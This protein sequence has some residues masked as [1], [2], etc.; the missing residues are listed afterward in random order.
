M[1]DGSRLVG[2]RWPSVGGERQ[3]VGGGGGRHWRCC[4]RLQFVRVL[5]LAQ[6]CSQLVVGVVDVGLMA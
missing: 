2:C 1:L 3:S 6:V 5:A 4:N